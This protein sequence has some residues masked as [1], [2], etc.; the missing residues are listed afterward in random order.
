MDLLAVLDIVVMERLGD[1][2]FRLVGQ[3]PRWFTRLC[4]DAAAARDRARP[5]R[6]LLFLEHFMVDA[7]A[8]WGRPGSG[9]LRSG[10]WSED[11]QRGNEYPLEAVA[12]RAGERKLLYLERPGAHYRDTKALLQKARENRLDYERLVQTQEALRRTEAELH[13][14]LARLEQSHADLLSILGRL[15]VGTVLLDAGGRIVFLN[16][17]CQ[18]ILGKDPKQVS[19]RNWSAALPLSETTKARLEA[20]LRRPAQERAR[21]STH[22]ETPDGQHYWMEVDVQDAPGDPERRILFLYD[23]SEV[24]DLRR[25][26]HEKT[27]SQSL[28]GGSEPML[29]VYR[30]IYNL[31]QVET[32]VLIEGETGTGKELV[33]REIHATSAR[34]DRPFV[35][36]NCAGLTESLLASQLFG[37]KRGAFTGAVSDQQ[38]VFEAANGGTLFLDEIG[39]ISALVQTSLLRVLQEREIVRLG[40]SKPRKI[41]VRILLA[42]N[43][44][45]QQAV[46]GGAFRADLFYRIRVARL[47]LP[48]LRERLQDVPLLVGAFLSQFHAAM[49]KPVEAVSQEAMGL[50]Q[51]YPWPG[52][53]RE[54]RSAIEFAVIRCRS[55]VIKPEDLPAEIGDAGEPS[56]SAPPLPG[57]ERQRLLAALEQSGG[58]R[59]A[60][61][62]LLGMSRATF[63]RRLADF[64]IPRNS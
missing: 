3:L 16:P 52:N 34:K 47:R 59:T 22:L 8:F 15:R 18:R 17:A 9:Q 21:I 1:G 11:N 29:A 55:A 44:D 36:V 61:A 10:P 12:I 58:N 32:T 13:E 46:T 19:G 23:L 28:V 51:A 31:A 50:L 49:G 35:A 62:R 53:V 33:A 45:L 38:G 30:D 41:N 43:R 39:D 37:H 57:D 56:P 2:A 7:E 25:L 14:T 48:P 63:Y 6:E 20:M 27:R 54:L 26:L 60:A 24:Q 40:E 64:G 5:E 42:T 4:P